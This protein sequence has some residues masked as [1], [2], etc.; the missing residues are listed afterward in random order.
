MWAYPLILYSVP[1]EFVKDGVLFLNRCT[2]P[3]R[4]EFIKISYVSRPQLVLIVVV[5]SLTSSQ[6][7]SRRR[8]LDH[9]VC[10]FHITN[11]TTI[12]TLEPV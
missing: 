8:F 11:S 1:Q 4:R 2:K 10:L 3:D 5:V 9:G 7:S 6:S 12:L